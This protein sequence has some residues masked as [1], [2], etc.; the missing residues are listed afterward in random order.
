MVGPWPHRAFTF[1]ALSM[2]GLWSVEV[3]K[4][5]GGKPGGQYLEPSSWRP[6]YRI[7]RHLNG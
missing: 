1:R 5:P 3:F 4:G 7:L 6:A 2:T